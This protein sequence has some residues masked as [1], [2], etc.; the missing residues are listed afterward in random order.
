V[1]DKK[2]EHQTQ[3]NLLN[4]VPFQK[5]KSEIQEDGLV[6]LLKPKY[7]HPFLAKHLLPRMK[8]PY[9]KIKLD[10]IGS[11]FWLN[12]DGIRTVKEIAELHKRKFGENVEPLY[13]RIA[14]FIASLEK[15]RLIIL[16]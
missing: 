6:I 15:N 11:F 13:E 14:H 3:I 7:F 12:C 9:F 16:K 5:I 8:Q 2:D 1:A 4:L 10:E